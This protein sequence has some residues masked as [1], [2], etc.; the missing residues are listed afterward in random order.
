MKDNNFLF[1]ASALYTL[2]TAYGN[3]IDKIYHSYIYI[4][5]DN[6][7][8]IKINHSYIYILVTAH[9]NYS[10]KVDHSYIYILDFNYTYILDHIFHERRI[11]NFTKASEGIYEMLKDFMLLHYIHF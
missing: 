9:G 3:Y 6:Y 2:L 4:K 10:D 7:T 1:D 8:Y 5:I 11:T